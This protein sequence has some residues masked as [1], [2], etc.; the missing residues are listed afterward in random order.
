MITNKPLYVQQVAHIFP[1]NLCDSDEKYDI[2]NG[3]LL[4][5]ELHILFDSDGYQFRI[6]PETQIISFSKEILEDTA[7]TEYTKYHNTKINLSNKNI[8]YLKKKYYA[9]ICIN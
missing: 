9:E 2:E 5:A 6:N 3:F 8:Y 1:H 7:M 4:S